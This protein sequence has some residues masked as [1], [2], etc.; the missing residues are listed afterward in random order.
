M[1]CGK[2]IKTTPSLMFKLEAFLFL[3]NVNLKRI[4]SLLTW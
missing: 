4:S 3:F 1:K 2:S